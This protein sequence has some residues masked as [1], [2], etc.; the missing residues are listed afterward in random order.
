MSLSLLDFSL[1]LC[2]PSS[3]RWLPSPCNAKPRPR[4][5]VLLQWV[6]FDVGV[7]CGFLDGDW[8]GVGRGSLKSNVGCGS[9]IDVGH[10]RSWWVVVALGLRIM[11]D[12]RVWSSRFC[13]FVCLVFFLFFFFF[14][15]CCCYCCLKEDVGL[16]WFCGLS[17]FGLFFILILWVAV[18]LIFFVL[19]DDFGFQLIKISLGTEFWR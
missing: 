11:V 16:V 10:G 1:S 14:V 9:W 12:R 19:K 13:L 17:W 6:C 15:F 3:H 4:L 2:S 18:I 5:D 7:V 8:S